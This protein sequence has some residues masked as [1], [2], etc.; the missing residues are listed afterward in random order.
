MLIPVFFAV[1]TVQDG[2]AK[3]FRHLKQM[4]IS[5]EIMEHILSTPPEEIYVLSTE[6]LEKYNFATELIGPA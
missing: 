4:G 1:Q 3:T 6:E 5:T 2:Q